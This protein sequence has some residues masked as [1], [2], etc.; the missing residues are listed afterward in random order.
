MTA[1]EIARFTGPLGI[2]AGPGAGNADARAAG[3]INRLINTLS[4]AGPLSGAQRDAAWRRALGA[5]LAGAPQR[6]R[7]AALDCRPDFN[8][9]MLGGLAA[10][11]ARHHDD[12]MVDVTRGVW[13]RLKPGS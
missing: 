1:D 10:C 4:D 11:L 13:K 8:E 2:L 12:A 7:R 6:V 9:Q 3:L 5:E